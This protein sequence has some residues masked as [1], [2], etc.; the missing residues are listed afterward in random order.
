MFQQNPDCLSDEGAVRVCLVPKS[1]GNADKKVADDCYWLASVK[2]PAEYR[3]KNRSRRPRHFSFT[4]VNQCSKTVDVQFLLG[5]PG[6]ETG[7]LKFL[8][9]RC[10][11]RSYTEKWG[12]IANVRIGSDDSYSVSCMS[13]AYR[14]RTGAERRRDFNLMATGYDGTPIS[15]VPF[16]PEVVLEK[17]GDP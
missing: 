6:S 4:V 2:E 9:R 1:L 13:V 14:N 3:R 11:P 15:K 5:E 12:E 16:D 17:A 7:T 10:E 8:T